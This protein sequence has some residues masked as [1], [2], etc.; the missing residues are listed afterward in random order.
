[1]RPAGRS[2][3]PLPKPHADHGGRRSD[4]DTIDLGQVR[5]GQA[6]QLRAQI[7]LRVLGLPTQSLHRGQATFFFK[8]QAATIFAI[9]TPGAMLCVGQKRSKVLSA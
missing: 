2:H 1:V 8:V 4:I 6:K 5:A 9:A 3:A 7:K